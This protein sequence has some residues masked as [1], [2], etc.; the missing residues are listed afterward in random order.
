MKRAS[1]F[2]VFVLICLTLFCGCVDNNA[3]LVEGTYECENIEYNEDKTI[4]KISI[5][6]SKASVEDYQ[7]DSSHIIKIKDSYYNTDFEIYID[8]ELY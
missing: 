6:I 5:T 1:I 3:Y 7:K 2:I 8:G 4:N